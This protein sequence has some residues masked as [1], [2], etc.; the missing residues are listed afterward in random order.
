MAG[1]DGFKIDTAGV[2]EFNAQ[3]QANVDKTIAPATERI[4]QAM[5]SYPV[6]GHRSGSPTVQAAA[7]KYYGQMRD[8]VA[9]LDTLVHNT[10]TIIKATQDAV[11]AYRAGDDVSAAM[12]AQIIGSAATK[13]TN[14]EA[15]AARVEHDGALSDL[16]RG[17]RQ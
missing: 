7:T 4:R 13:T 3:L 5:M 14:A 15:E 8:A 1:G 2:A 16:H 6:F 10:N 17:D 11:A 12:M 9:F